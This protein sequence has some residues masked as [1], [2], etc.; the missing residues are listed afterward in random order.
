MHHNNI[1]RL[2]ALF[3]AL[4]EDKYLAPG[5]I[6]SIRPNQRDGDNLLAD[7]ELKPF[8]KGTG[9]DSC[10]TSNDVRDWTK[11]GFAVPGD[12][13]LDSEGRDQIALYLRD[14]YYW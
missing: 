14:T 13:K 11:T 9:K 7:D 4:Y 5:N 12:R 1:D 8:R 6:D 3:Q 10:F 2:F